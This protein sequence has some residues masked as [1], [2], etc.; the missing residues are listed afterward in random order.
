MIPAPQLR[1]AA[2]AG[3]LH[4]EGLLDATELLPD[5][6]AAARSAA[7]H[8]DPAGLRMRLAHAMADSAT[9]HAAARG[10]AARDVARAVEDALAARRP[11]AR[12]LAAAESAD[13]EQVLSIDEREEIIQAGL[14][15]ALRRF[16]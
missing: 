15:R 14:R 12:I 6:L 5:L 1:A 11:R 3:R 8:L 13:P 2:V 4:A 9:A 7:P 10:R 16:A